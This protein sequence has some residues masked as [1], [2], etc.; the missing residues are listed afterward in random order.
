VLPLHKLF[1]LWDSLLLA[2]AS[3]PLFIGVAILEEL[4]AD[5]MAAHFNDA[6]LLF[7]DL[8]GAGMGT[9]VVCNKCKKSQFQICQLTVW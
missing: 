2:D 5:L 7:S 6:I 4:R 1:H 3:F 8:P 9:H